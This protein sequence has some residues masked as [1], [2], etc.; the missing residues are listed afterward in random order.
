M[1]SN[2]AI[3]KLWLATTKLEGSM[4]IQKHERK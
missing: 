4:C 3:T 1:L 2:D